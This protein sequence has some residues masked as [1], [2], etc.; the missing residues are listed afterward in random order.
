MDI[1]GTIIIASPHEDV[2][3]N[4]TGVMSSQKMK[5][6]KDAPKYALSGTTAQGNS[7]TGGPA[8]FLGWYADE[9]QITKE[10]EEIRDAIAKGVSRYEL[11]YSVKVERHWW[12]LKIV[13]REDFQ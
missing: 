2:T 3:V 12:R 4:C 11:K 9:G 10:I 8:V 1:T 13:N 7:L 5:G 6:G